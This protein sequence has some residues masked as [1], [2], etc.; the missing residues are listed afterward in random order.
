MR[1][2]PAAAALLWAAA[3]STAPAGAAECSVQASAVDFGVYDS[4][5]PTPADSVGTV[6][7]SCSGFAGETIAYRIR[8][9]TGG[10]GVF[11]PRAM[12]DATTWR[13][14]Y[15]LY[16]NAARTLVWGDGTGASRIVSD[17]YVL[18]SRG[19]ARTYPVYGR[20]PGRQHVAPGS[21]TDTLVVTLDY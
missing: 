16:V 12:S 17:A 10:S 3:L 1:R 4:F 6:A 9:G 20:M 15:N 8:I 21:Y 7:V 2:L 14:L 11:S 18:P 5:A 13:L 19:I